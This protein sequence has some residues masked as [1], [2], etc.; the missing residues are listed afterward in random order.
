MQKLII[1]REKGRRG[2][3]RKG[4]AFRRAVATPLLL[5]SRAG[6]QVRNK[7]RFCACWGRVQPARDLRFA[8]AITSLENKRR[9][10]TSRP[11][12]PQQKEIPCG[13]SAQDDR[14]DA[15]GARSKL[16]RGLAYD[17]ERLQ[18]RR[19]LN[20]TAGCCWVPGWFHRRCHR[21]W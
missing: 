8:R 9:S 12:D 20:R 1:L 18:A 10:S 5:S 2:C 21:Q 15:R 19:C 16:I 13:R 14:H 7:R 11:P 17:A 6:E 3:E 4:R